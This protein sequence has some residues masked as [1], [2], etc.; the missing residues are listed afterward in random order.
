MFLLFFRHVNGCV[1]AGLANGTVVVF[2]RDSEGEW[3]LSRYHIV[4]IG[5]PIN[6]VIKVTVVGDKVWCGIKN[7]IHVLDPIELKIVHSFEAHPRS[8]S[9]V[10]K[11]NSFKH[12]EKTKID[13]SSIRIDNNACNMLDN[14]VFKC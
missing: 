9:Q 2:R 5:F 3:D 14:L 7:M 8:E 13:R 6:S 1:V 4:K 11:K 10:S 12:I